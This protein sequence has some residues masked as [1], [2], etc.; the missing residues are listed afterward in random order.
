MH[1][2][3]EVNLELGMPVVADALRRLTFEIHNSKKMNCTVLKIIHGYGST[4]KGGKI[5]TASRE[6]LDFF[7]SKNEIKGYVTGEN[8][9]IFDD[10]TRKA[11]RL[12]PELRK[13][14]DLERCNNGVSFIM[15]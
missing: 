4:G 6:R 13:D 5:R 1:T 12:C 8:F 15:L 3:R 14:R 2:L 9:S 11:L 7:T 10:T